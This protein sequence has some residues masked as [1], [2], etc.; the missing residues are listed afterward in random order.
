MSRNSYHIIANIDG[1]WNVTRTGAERAT[2]R[3]ATQKDA[4]E[5]GRNISRSHATELIIHDRDGR[6]LGKEPFGNDPNPPRESK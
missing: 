4:I 6:L 1:G 2:R 3:F 5:F